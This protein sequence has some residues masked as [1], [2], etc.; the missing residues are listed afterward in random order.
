MREDS[1]VVE[2]MVSGSTY[3]GETFK[4]LCPNTDR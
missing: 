3:N 2:R 1:F 4:V